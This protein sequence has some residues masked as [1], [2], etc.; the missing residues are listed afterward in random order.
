M[1]SLWGGNPDQQLG[2]SRNNS[3]TLGPNG[4]IY[5]L[6]YATDRVMVF[7]GDGEF[8]NSFGGPG[9]GPGELRGPV[10]MT[11]DDMDRLWVA[12][13]QG[14]YRRLRFK[15]LVPEDRAKI[16]PSFLKRLQ[17]PLVWK[18][19][20][21]LIEEAGDGD[22][23]VV[24]YLRVDTLGNFVDTVAVIPTPKLSPGF[25]GIRMRPSWEAL[26]FVVQHY[27]AD[28]RWALGPDGTVWSAETGRLRLTQT[29]L[30]GDPIRIVET[31]HRVTQL[32][33]WDHAKI[34]DG[35]NEAGIS[36]RDVELVRPAVHG[37]HV[38]DDGHVLVGIIERVGEVPSTFDVFDPEGLYLG[39][40]DL[41][42]GIS[43]RS[44]PALVGDTIIAV[45]PGALDVP[46]L[47][48]ATIERPQ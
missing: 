10:A 47:V 8:V 38:M 2:S 18:A 48:R 15:R 22:A 4:Q 12:E 25:R 40:I 36:R 41:G 13:G 37:V 23:E 46:Y 35:L 42:F 34:A 27:Q 7:S 44:L 30:G 39:A 5:V 6:E 45:T 11:W 29:A 26:H 32:G 20:G 17:R 31:S 28:L 21:T 43:H 19:G 9:E 16:S 1:G 24:L 33:P 14:R 3:V